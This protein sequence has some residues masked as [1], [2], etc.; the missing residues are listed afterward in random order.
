MAKWQYIV[1]EGR[2]N[3]HKQS[4]ILISRENP[5][6]TGLKQQLPMEFDVL[7]SSNKQNQ[8]KNHQNPT[9]MFRIYPPLISILDVIT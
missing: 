9:E 4:D 6:Q 2:V 8:Q 3:V 1:L 7:K 5:T